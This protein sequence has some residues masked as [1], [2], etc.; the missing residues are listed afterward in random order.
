LGLARQYSS[1]VVVLTDKPTASASLG[2]LT[3]LRIEPRRSRDRDGWFVVEH[4][5]LKN[6]SGAPFSSEPDRYQG[7]WGL[8]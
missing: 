8:R 2:P 5:V 1:L 3:G 4:E 7:P 6:K